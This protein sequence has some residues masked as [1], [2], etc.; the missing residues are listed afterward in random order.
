[1]CEKPS[2]PGRPSKKRKDKMI[3]D[4][5]LQCGGEGMGIEA[6]LAPRGVTFASL[7]SSFW[8]LFHPSA[9]ASD[10]SDRFSGLSCQVPWHTSVKK[11]ETETLPAELYQYAF[12][13]SAGGIY[14]LGA[15]QERGL[16]MGRLLRKMVVTQMYLAA[17][18]GS[19]HIQ[20][21]LAWLGQWEFHIIYVN[22]AQPC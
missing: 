5:S 10:T 16:K 18:Y 4:Y 6:S 2:L 15:Q 12:G 7:F 14:Q 22:L 11:K 19:A 3:Q 21:I 1:M 13:R 20:D 9:V 8:H 17:Q